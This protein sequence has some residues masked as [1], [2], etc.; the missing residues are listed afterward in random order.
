MPVTVVV[1]QVASAF[2]KPARAAMY[3]DALPIAGGGNCRAR[4]QVD[5]GAEEQVEMTVAIIVDK[6]AASAPLRGGQQQA[7]FTGHIGERAVAI[8][9]K[10]DILV[11]IRDEQIVQTIVVVIADGH[12]RDP[13]RTRQAG[14]RGDIEERSIAIVLV[15]PVAG[16]HGRSPKSSATQNQNVEPAV[17]IEIEERD[18]ASDGFQN[19]L[20]SIDASINAG[21]IKAGLSRDV[22]EL[23]VER[24]AG[25]LGALLW[26]DVARRHALREKRSL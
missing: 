13:A 21:S 5:V 6:G 1:K 11:I 22:G 20:L 17:V 16:S 3:G 15:Q 14:F 19:V 26:M 7:R 23:G 4:V 9:A 8:I 10:Q 2:G 24:Q 25:A 12:A 18:A